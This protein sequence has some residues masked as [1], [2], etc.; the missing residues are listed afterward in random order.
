MTKYPEELKGRLIAKM[1]PPNNAKIADLSRDT[2]IPKETLY[3]WRTKNK[4][5]MGTDKSHE[6]DLTSLNLASEDKFAI[7]V[8][9]AP[10]NESEISEYCRRK[11][12]YPNQIQAWRNTC[13]QANDIRSSRCDQKKMKQ[14]TEDI[15]CLE[16]ELRR[17]DKALAEAAALLLLKKK[18]QEIWGEPEDEKPHQRKNKK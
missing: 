14:Q 6:S 18:V 11:G 15:K 5:R 2:G 10:M 1:L 16:K 12:L 7:V 9:T 17:K 13:T 4:R 8:E 3:T